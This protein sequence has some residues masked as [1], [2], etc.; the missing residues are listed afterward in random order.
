MQKT[1][2]FFL[3]SELDLSS[4]FGDHGVDC[5]PI[6]KVT[7]TGKLTVQNNQDHLELDVAQYRDL[8]FYTSAA[9]DAKQNKCAAER[10]DNYKTTPLKI[11]F[12]FIIQWKIISFK[13]HKIKAAIIRERE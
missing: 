7:E 4:H 13:K 1:L 6:G 11:R 5:H 3:Q 9:L 8:W 2:V 12:S 10:F